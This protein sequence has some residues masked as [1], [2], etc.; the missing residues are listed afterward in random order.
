VPPS[1]QT[2]TNATLFEN[3]TTLSGTVSIS[4]LF[5]NPIGG[6]VQSL[7]AAKVRQH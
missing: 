2:Y 6:P 1:V 7:Q 5:Y 3:V 4:A